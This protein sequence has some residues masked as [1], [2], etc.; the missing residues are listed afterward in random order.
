MSYFQRA[1]SLAPD[2]PVILN[3]LGNALFNLNRP[4]EA[5]AA[6]QQ[7]TTANP[8]YPKQYRNLALLYQLQNRNTNAIAAYRQYLSLA[9]GD[10]EGHHNLCL[11]CLA[12]GITARSISSS[13][14]LTAT[15]GWYLEQRRSDA[16][17]FDA[18]QTFIA[19]KPIW[20]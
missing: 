8:D 3:N 17:R 19:E 7:A 13:T 12:S 15:S 20:W 1:L 5:E 4:E 14:I 16:P 9:P 2:S 6:Y 11:L 18:L 10:G